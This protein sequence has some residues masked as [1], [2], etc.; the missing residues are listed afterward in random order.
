MSGRFTKPIP[1]KLDRATG[2][3]ISELKRVSRLTTS[4]ILRRAVRFSAPKFLS[5]EVPLIDLSELQS[6]EPEPA[7]EAAEGTDEIEGAQG[8]QAA[9]DMSDPTAP[10]QGGAK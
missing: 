7:T 3:V 5:G 9:D 4:E 1:V 8:G 6:E 2:D 10:G